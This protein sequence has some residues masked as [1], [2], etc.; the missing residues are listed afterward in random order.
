MLG[1][2]KA[3]R[4]ARGGSWDEAH[5]GITPAI[6][7]LM[8]A[9]ELLFAN[10]TRLLWGSLAADR[11]PAAAA[12]SDEAESFFAQ[13]GAHAFV[14]QFRESFVRAEASPGA[15]R[16]AAAPGRTGATVEG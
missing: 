4:L 6:A 14:R 1:A 2:V 5:A 3:A 12:G 15:K 16:E 9:G 7:E 13:R 11:E 10:L 8:A